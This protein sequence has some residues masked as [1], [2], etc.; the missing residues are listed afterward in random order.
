VTVEHAPTASDQL[1]V[2]ELVTV[3]P[4]EQIID[5]LDDPRRYFSEARKRARRAVE[6]DVLGDLAH[7][8]HS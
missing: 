3:E 6:A 5:L 7:V 4:D 2:I 8:K 1:D